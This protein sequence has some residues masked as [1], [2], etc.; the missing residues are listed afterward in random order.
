MAITPVQ[1]YI[2]TKNYKD[3]KAA[4]NTSEYTKPRNPQGHL[5][6]DTLKSMPKYWLQDIAY[7]MRAV[8]DGFRGTANDHQTG[9]L[10]EVGLK[11]GGIGIATYLASKTSDP[12]A[13]LMEYVGLAAFLASMSL[14]PKIAVNVPSR[15]VHGFDIGKK[16]IDDQGRK[17]SVFQDSNYI[18][19][20]M[21]KG[22]SP[23]EDLDIIGDRLGIPRDIK[24]RHDVIKEQ[25]RKIA[26]Q[27]NTLWMLTGGFATP[28]MAALICYGADKAISN[29]LE[30]ARNMSYKGKISDLLQKTAD[31]TEDI[32]LIEPNS[33]SERVGKI[34]NAYKGKE[35]PKDEIDKIFNLITNETDS[36]ISDG[37][38]SD[39][40]KLF[41]AEGNG[42]I[43]GENAAEQ[44]IESIRS[45]IGSVNKDMLT[46]VFVPTKE[47]LSG[48]LSKVKNESQDISQD[49]LEKLKNE[50]KNLYKSKISSYPEAA[51]ALQAKQNDIINSISM[52]IKKHPAYLVNDEIADDVVNFAKIMGEFKI[53]KIKLDK[54]ESFHVE[55]SPETIIAKYYE[56]FQS[57][58]L[59][60]LGLNNS[61]LKEVREFS[62]Y[63]SEKL[64]EKLTAL[65]ND[66]AKY[67][68]AIKRLAKVMSDM[69]KELDGESTSA[70][71]DLISAIENN[72]NK[73]ALRI[74]N[75][76][77]DKFSETI[78]RLV[79]EQVSEDMMKNTLSTKEDL[80]KVLDGR[81]EVIRGGE[82]LEDVLKVSK[83]VGSSKNN[84]IARIV[85]RYQEV[86]NAFNRV[87]H[88]MDIYKREIPKDSTAQSILKTGKEVLLNASSKNHTLKL[89]MENNPNYYKHVFE[90]IWSGKL[91]D[92]T[93]NT[94]DSVKDISGVKNSAGKNSFS[95]RFTEYINRFRSVIGN[96][97]IDFTKLYH[98]VWKSREY[99]Q[100]AMT[101]KSKFDLVAQSPVDMLTDG[102]AKKYGNNMWLK[103]AC[104]IAG[105][106]FGVAFLSQFTFGKIKNPHNLQKQVKN[107]KNN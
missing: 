46:N 95:A 4:I 24:N 42:Y 22:D 60:I 79:K 66:S 52:S 103:R 12:K 26:T 55:Y 16:Y 6:H 78:D 51:E 63:A 62:K 30:K 45:R 29:G 83:G 65:C 50:L 80:F 28:V 68:K 34:V 44:I 40:A 105:S 48:I 32:N 5:V 61:E 88:T 84:E 100:D 64:D 89:N 9:R 71:K 107:D 99:A 19:F 76:G 74:S 8:R 23:G 27:N 20:D 96:C 73:T 93:Q 49:G 57:E 75:I 85:E 21:Y 72:Y 98:R 43:F 14:Y 38:K 3:A 90:T 35:I 101:R 15:V 41:R 94:L 97:D 7:D 54:C 77:D 56:K 102:A 82:A 58:F 53:N 17:K 36:I 69:D 37:V 91:E 25:M 1:P 59:N 70:L 13:R 86:R 33:L 31:M 47:E 18:P 10:N 39:L 67:E 11:A 87:L 104:I 92:V 106:V 81:Q 2:E